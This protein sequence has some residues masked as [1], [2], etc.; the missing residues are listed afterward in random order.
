MADGTSIEW[1]D[2]TWN[3]NRGCTRVSLGCQRCYAEGIAERFSGPGKP[4]EGYARRGMGTASAWTGKIA[5]IEHALQQ[6]FE[7]R[8]PRMIFVN[9]MSDTFHEALTDEQIAVVI[10]H[11]IAAHHLRGHTMQILTKRAYRMWKLLND[12]K[13]WD[14]VNAV[15]A[16]QMLARIED[17]T[18]AGAR[19]SAATQTIQQYGPKNPPP[20]LWLMVSAET[21]RNADD[22][23]PLL[24]DTPARIRGLSAEPLLGEI[25]LTDMPANHADD[26]GGT[27]RINAL[28][29]SHY[30]PGAGS[31]S[32]QTFRGNPRLDWVISGGE[33]GIDARP[34]HPDWHRSLRDQC[35]A[36]GTAYHFKQ[37]GAWTPYQEGGLQPVIGHSSRILCADGSS[38]WLGR[39]PVALR[40]GS[41]TSTGNLLDGQRH[42]EFPDHGKQ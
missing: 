38:S 9:S 29:G 33:S 12:S 34:S 28:E 41:K 14:G 2:A 15:A 18:R 8:E 13:W 40:R 35:R 27:I 22:R 32:S 24:L 39:R 5:L 21:Q 37:W 10:G 36:A 25:R 20:G 7:W 11:A 16:A 42:Q 31:V 30:M 6:P 26:N 17:G 4:Y 1:T 23:V 3:P 19:A